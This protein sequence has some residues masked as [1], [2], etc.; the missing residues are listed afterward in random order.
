MA[1]VGH[2]DGVGVGDGGEELVD[3]VGADQVGHRAAD[4]EC[5]GGDAAGA[6]EELVG[7]LSEALFAVGGVGV[8][9]VDL[10]G[11]ECRVPAP[12]PAAVVALA[13]YFGESVDV[14]GS[15]PVRVV[16]GDHVAGVV[17]GGE[18]VGVRRHE[19]HDS[20]GAVDFHA[21]GDVDEH[22]TGPH[23]GWGDAVR[24]EDRHA[25]HR[26]A[27]NDRG[28]RSAAVVADSE[29]VVGEVVCVIASGRVP[30]AVAVP[31]GV[32][33]DDVV[34]CGVDGA[35]GLGPGVAVLS[36]S[37]QQ[38]HRWLVTVWCVGRHR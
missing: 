26:R 1:G 10:G 20:S 27:D 28:S 35:G 5:G 23:T 25:A 14:V 21:R 31:A 30:A 9:D 12:H 13:Q 36:A 3:G 33:G 38:D 29:Q 19:L 8:H 32:V 18:S 17:Q 4:E 6:V 11:D 7:D 34:A 15:G 37:V 22:D 16:G 24:S 2:V